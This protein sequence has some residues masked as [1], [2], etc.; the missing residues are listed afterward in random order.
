MYLVLLNFYLYIEK[1]HIRGPER[2]CR[3]LAQMLAWPSF[4]STQSDAGIKDQVASTKF[5]KRNNTSKSKS[6]EAANASKNSKSITPLL[7]SCLLSWMKQSIADQQ[8]LPLHVS[9][10]DQTQRNDLDT[11]RR[12]ELE[13]DE[14]RTLV[15]QVQD[16][17]QKDNVYS[18]SHPLSQVEYVDLSYEDFVHGLK[19][20]AAR[21]QN[22]SNACRS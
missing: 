10:L 19:V 14:C 22:N 9:E 8:V 3:A 5:H 20:I 2:S 17:D 6:E 16:E 7:A 15:K 12:R 4:R 13:A 1:I 21:K 11:N 18:L